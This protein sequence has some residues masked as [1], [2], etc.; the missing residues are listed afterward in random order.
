MR[1]GVW[2]GKEVAVKIISDMS[3]KE[4]LQ[5]EAKIIWLLRHP[6]IISLMG[7]Y[8]LEHDYCLVMEFIRVRFFD[9]VHFTTAYLLVYLFLCKLASIDRGQ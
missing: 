6:N 9:N 1:R 3:I 2:D 7:V 8:V 4:M 5:N